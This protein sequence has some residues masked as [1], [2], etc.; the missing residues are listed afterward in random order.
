M[1]WR[2]PGRRGRL[3]CQRT[4]YVS[5]IILSVHDLIRNLVTAS[6]W[7]MPDP[8]TT[9]PPYT[10]RIPASSNCKTYQS[11]DLF[12][13]GSSTVR[14]LF[15]SISVHLLISP[16][17]R[18]PVLQPQQ[19]ARD[20]PPPLAPSPE[21]ALRLRAQASLRQLSLPYASHSWACHLCLRV[22]SLVVGWF[23][24]FLDR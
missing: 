11:T 8:L 4:K 6:T 14:S 12:L 15:T 2:C 20:P 7:S 10:P 18:R 17:R 23:F 19:Q 5:S 24:E 3:Q 13:A 22:S 1:R 21:A 16:S 9:T